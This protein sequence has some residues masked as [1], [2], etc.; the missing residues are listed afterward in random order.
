MKIV[1]P[2]LALIWLTSEIL[3]RSY[4]DM[5]GIFPLRQSYPLALVRKM[6]EMLSGDYLK[7][8][9]PIEIQGLGNGSGWST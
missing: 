3:D 5:L 2:L 7:N 8:I 4:Y 6:F 9:T 1:I